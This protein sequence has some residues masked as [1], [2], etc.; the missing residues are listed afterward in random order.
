M[1]QNNWNL[2]AKGRKTLQKTTGPPGWGL[3]NGPITHSRKNNKITET[4]TLRTFS[5]E[6]CATCDAPRDSYLRWENEQ[7]MTS[8]SESHEEVSTSMSRRQRR[9]RRRTVE[10]EMKTRFGWNGWRE[11]HQ[12]AQD[13]EMWRQTCRASIST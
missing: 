4:Q 12:V 8:T 6:T 1:P 9:P 13:R 11:A 3:G 5:L 10:R 2:C 7:S